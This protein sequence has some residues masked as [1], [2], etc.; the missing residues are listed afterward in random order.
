MPTPTGSTTP[1]KDH[2]RH[3]GEWPEG[4][5]L[6]E[7]IVLDMESLWT[8]TGANEVGIDGHIELFDLAARRPPGLTL[9]AQSKVASALGKT[10]SHTF[11][12]WCAPADVEYWLPR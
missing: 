5:Q 4:R 7:R 1:L 3:G 8:P 12:L 11:D 2:F 9:A 6:I 10:S